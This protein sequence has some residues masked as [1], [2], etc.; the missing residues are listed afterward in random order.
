MELGRRRNVRV[1]D[2][3][4]RGAAAEPFGHDHEYSG[5]EEPRAEFD[6]VDPHLVCDHGFLG[7]QAG[8]EN[9]TVIVA[10]GCS[11]YGLYTLNVRYGLLSSAPARRR[12]C[13]SGVEP[14]EELLDRDL[15]V[16]QAMLSLGRKAS[17]RRSSAPALP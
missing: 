3:D 9:V 12:S 4:R 10:P 1:R 11:M 17:T 16:V 14:R 13:A 8:D 7:A 5:F 6:L 2:G 15:S